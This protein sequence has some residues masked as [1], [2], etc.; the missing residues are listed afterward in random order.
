MMK[1]QYRDDIARLETIL[2]GVLD[3]L[4]EIKG[5]MEDEI[6]VAAETMEAR[7]K[8][9]VNTISVIDAALESLEATID[10]LEP[11][12]WGEFRGDGDD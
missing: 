4:T 7:R 2:E 6:P 8:A 12:S 1:Q 5:D 11:L 3:E 10:V 9:W